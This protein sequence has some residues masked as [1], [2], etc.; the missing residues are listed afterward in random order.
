MADPA[1]SKD[2][3]SSQ[4]LARIQ[5]LESRLE[6][7]EHLLKN[8]GLRNA[9]Y[10]LKRHGSEI[11]E[12]YPENKM[13]IDYGAFQESKV[14]EYGFVWIS[15]IVYVFGI[16]FL[17]VYLRNLGYLY[18]SSIIGYTA[19]IG[20]FFLSYF[21]KESFPHLLYPLRI[22]SFLLLYYVTLRLHFFTNE[23]IL[24]F[25][26]IALM[27]LLATIGIQ[28]V[29][30][31]KKQ[32]E[33]LAAVSII[34]ILI[35][36]LIYNLTPVTLSLI[37]IVPIISVI[38][39][40]RFGWWRL[41]MMALFLVYFSHILWFLNDPLVGNPVQA[42][43]KPQGSIIYLFIYAI[44]FAST[45]V[46]P[47]KKNLSEGVLISLSF[48]NI[49]CFSLVIMM[50]ILSFY[51][52]HYSWI[53][54]LI[55][56]F[57]I[58]Y[59]LYLQTKAAQTFAPVFYACCGFMALSIAVY[60][61]TGF[62]HAYFYLALQSLLVVSLALWF[63]SKIIVL[64]N[65]ILY[66]ILLISYF[67]TATPIGYISLSFAFVALATA[68]VL[69]WKKERLT[70]KTDLLRNIYLISAFFT[71][72]YGLSHTVTDPFITLSWTGAALL[73]FMLSIV[74]KNIKY[75]WMSIMALL[76]SC[77]RL[78]VT[79]LSN[80]ETGYRVVAFLLFAVIALSVSIYYTKKIKNKT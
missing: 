24:P 61:Y 63:R 15:V 9:E 28:M 16:I 40:S 56:I 57:C 8:S 49:L 17:T 21:V 30:T 72:L 36:A 65:L 75:R 64:V 78:F 44:T 54:I 27:L 71:V 2:L 67:T 77:I 14:F 4:I 7:I 3:S 68:R 46:L 55:S 23:P 42:V 79:D 39:L 66:S 5:S 34:L 35:T 74:L 48:W 12:S 43:S 22:G 25:K 58:L 70:L 76:A 31:I 62:P 53:F 73:F 10:L 11:N 45:I 69:N 60:G 19:V 13:P 33:F 18:S 38:F 6:N 51:K 32:S 80:M 26:G 50:S 47:Q 37:T 59:S 20:A 41:T 29:Y 52:D 1:K